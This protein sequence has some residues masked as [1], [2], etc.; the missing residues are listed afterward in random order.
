[1]TIIQ[2]KTIR[3]LSTSYDDLWGDN[4]LHEK[5]GSMIESM[6]NQ[7]VKS[8]DDELYGKLTS[9]SYMSDEQKTIW[10][11]KS[12]LETQFGISYDEFVKIYEKLLRDNP[13]K[14]I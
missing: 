4:P 5:Y 11:V 14:L 1:M 7:M 3:E 6:I 9:G 2:P 13:E 12:G 10:I 8:I